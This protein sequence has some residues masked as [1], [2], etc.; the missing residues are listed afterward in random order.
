MN[1]YYTYTYYYKSGIDSAPEK[2]ITC[3]F[4]YNAAE[5][6]TK[7]FYY[8]PVKWVNK[9][10]LYF[11]SRKGTKKKNGQTFATKATEENLKKRA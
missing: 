4:R 5:M 10:Y 6:L 8:T 7:S 1:S 3:V 9:Y 2:N 11:R